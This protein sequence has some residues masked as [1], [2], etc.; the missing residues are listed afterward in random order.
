MDTFN[1]YQYDDLL[2]RSKDVYANTKY[3]VIVE[4]LSGS[5]GLKIL[6]G[7]CG[8]GE[9]SFLLANA[10]HQVTGI[11]PAPEYI[12]VAQQN[13]ARF[14]A[15]ECSFAVSTIEDF[16]PAEL[17]DCV[18]ATDVLE[19]IEDD[20]TAFERFVQLV[21]PGGQIILTV[22]AGQW[23]FG[24]HD[25]ALGHFRRYSAS[26]LRRLIQE[27]CYIEQIR[28]FGFTLIPVCYLY[29]KVL[30]K[31]YPVAEAGDTSQ[32]PFVAATL[33]TLLAVDKALPMPFGTSIIM[34]GFRKH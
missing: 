23:L 20:R 11:D 31:P 24:Y 28:Y 32:N 18:I 2:I 33:S 25:K 1:K 10:G 7:G 27:R 29:S 19:H 30:R 26:L 16:V 3:S 17:F 21:K 22:P 34:K 15:L 8:S 5:T 4:Y 9:L 13:V 12:E 14:G 6:N